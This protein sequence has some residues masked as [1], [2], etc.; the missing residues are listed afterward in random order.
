[1]INILMN[2]ISSEI[3]KFTASHTAGRFIYMLSGREAEKE[4]DECKTRRV[5]ITWWHLGAITP[6]GI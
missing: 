4:A 1:M 3:L 5:E 6:R 2:K